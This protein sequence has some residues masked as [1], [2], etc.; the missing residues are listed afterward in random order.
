MK[1]INPLKKLILND[2][3][4]MTPL[5]HH[6]AVEKYQGYPECTLNIKQLECVKKHEISKDE[7]KIAM[8]WAENSAREGLVIPGVISVRHD[9]EKVGDIYSMNMYIPMADSEP[10]KVFFIMVFEKDNPELLDQD[11]PIGLIA[12]HSNQ[13]IAA[14]S[15]SYINLP[16][17]STCANPYN[18]NLDITL[19]AGNNGKYCLMVNIEC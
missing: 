2:T 12:F 19:N 10:G 16:K 9:F 1:D 15:G 14:Y 11:D 4:V 13:V 8:F 5:D 3:S 7:I 6:T 18:K 17:P